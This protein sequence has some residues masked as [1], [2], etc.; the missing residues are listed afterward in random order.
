MGRYYYLNPKQILPS[1]DFLK[2]GTFRMIIDALE[3][4]QIDRL[5][6]PPIIRSVPFSTKPAAI[7]GHNLL[8]VKCLL[9]ENCLVYF[10]NDKLDTLSILSSNKGV[11]ERNKELKNKF[12]ASEM[13]AHRLYEEGIVGLQS[14]LNKYPDLIKYSK[15][16]LYPFPRIET[17]GYTEKAFVHGRFQPFH[18]QHFEYILSAKQRCDF[19]YIGITRSDPSLVS[20]SL[21]APHRANPEANLLTYHERTEM[22][23]QCLLSEGFNMAEFCFVPIPIDKPEYLPYFMDTDVKCFTTTCDEWNLHKISIL[24]EM[25]Y[26]VESLID[27]RGDQ[28]QKIYISGSMIRGMLLKND[29]AWMSMVSPIVARYL[30]KIDYQNRLID[31][32]RS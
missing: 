16:L 26:K 30:T 2:C 4:G 15:K 10:A 18:F 6:P 24:E 20:K 3:N 22:I 28:T 17:I 27:R 11:D 7:D 9:G 5:P 25:G 32:S 1:Q 19:L 13:E 14:L 8:A 12:D 21:V 31:C 29:K 23:S